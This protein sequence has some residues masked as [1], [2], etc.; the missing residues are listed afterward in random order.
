M[1]VSRKNLSLIQF[2]PAEATACIDVVHALHHRV[3]ALGV[4]CGLGELGK[5]IAESI[6]ERSALGAGDEAG[7]LD[8]VFVGAQG[9]VF[10]TRIVYTDFVYTGK[11][12]DRSQVFRRS[13]RDLGNW[14]SMKGRWNSSELSC[15]P[16]SGG[17]VVMD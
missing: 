7:P 1:F 13:G 11:T 9:D 15:L 14:F 2:I 3:E 5:P 12:S 4:S 6:V 10:H 17:Q 8:Q 16:G